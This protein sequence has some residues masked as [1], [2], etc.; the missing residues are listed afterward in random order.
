MHVFDSEAGIKKFETP[1]QILE[2]FYSIRLKFYN[3]R[4]VS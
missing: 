2:E 1:E 4:K 3:K